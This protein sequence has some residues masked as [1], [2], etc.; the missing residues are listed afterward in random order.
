[1]TLSKIRMGTAIAGLAAL[2]ASLLPTAAFAEIPSNQVPND[3]QAAIK[4]QVEARGNEYAGLCRVVNEGRTI[5]YG[6]WCAFVTSI[7]H[8]I[9]EINLGPVATNDIYFVSFDKAQSGWTVRQPIVK[10]QDQGSSNQTPGTST[11]KPPATGAGVIKT[12]D[13]GDSS[14]DSLL[15]VAGVGAVVAGAVAAG[16]VFA[17]RGR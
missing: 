4:A 13:E 12:A 6:E 14:G 8:D 10:V 16:G 1:M 5:P 11:P 3:L 15:L 17:L 7:E 2:A 9:A